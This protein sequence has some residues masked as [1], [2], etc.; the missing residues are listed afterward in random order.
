MIK[1]VFILLLVGGLTSTF[2]L[3]GE[4][5]DKKVRNIHDKAITVDTH[6]D[7]PMALLNESFD[8]GKRNKAPQSR[9]DFPRMEEGGLDAIFFAAFTGQKERTPENTQ[10]AYSLAHQMIDRTYA[11]CEQYKDVAAVATKA[12]DVA[13]LERKGIGRFA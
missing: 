9:V 3:F 5:V 12:D 8:V 2:N 10:K 7:T 1:A 6:V 4:G 13:S 11:V